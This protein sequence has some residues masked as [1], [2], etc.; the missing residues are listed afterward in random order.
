MK[1]RA[2]I[3]HLGLGLAAGIT[4]PGWLT[5]CTEEKINTR[6]NYEGVIGVIGAGA[7]G[8]CAA[9]IL[10]SAGL[11]VRIFEASAQIGGRVRS[12]NRFDTPG[13]ALQVNPDNFPISDFP[14]EL[15]A[16][17]VWGSDAVW[18]KQVLQTG[19]PTLDYIPVATDHAYRIND[20]LY[21]ESVLANN[22]AFQAALAFYNTLLEKTGTGSVQQAIIEA[23]IDPTLYS[24]LNSWIGNQYGSRNDKLGLNPIVEIADRAVRNDTR[25]LI[26]KNNMQDVLLA[27]F[28][29]AVKKVEVNSVIEQVDHAG[30]KVILSGSQGGSV[31]ST[32]V[33]HV[34][35]A[36]PVQ[37]MQTGKIQ[38]TPALPG[39]KTSALNMMKMDASVRMFIEFKKNFWGNTLGH[40]QGGEKAS[41]YFNAGLGRS[42]NPRALSITAQGPLAQVLSDAGEQAPALILDELDLLYNGQ[43]TQNVRRTDSNEVLAVVMDWTK[44]PYIGGGTT[45]IKPGGS[46]QDRINLAAPVN[47]KLFFAG[48]ATDT[49]GDADNLN[50]AIRSGMRAAEEIKLLVTAQ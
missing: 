3:Q 8:L 37:V 17:E 11:Q 14:V 23:G 21:L 19:V 46:N 45:Y 35:V 34:I 9:D 47:D 12:L 38:F 43:A 22:E 29:R 20:E 26:S 36:V 15:G 28:D 18:A 4:L 27:R 44:E 13:P 6:L 48:E 2:A 30:E 41:S 32:T 33:D 1:R 25:L 39:I 42:A 10:L 24:T 31:F 50:G 7:A 5:S 16:A 49:Q 40:L